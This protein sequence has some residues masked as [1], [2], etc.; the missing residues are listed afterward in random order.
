MTARY[1]LRSTAN[2]RANCRWSECFGYVV[3]LVCFAATTAAGQGASTQPR[4][5]SPSVPTRSQPAPPSPAQAPAPVLPTGV[6]EP[7]DYLIGADDLLT[8]FFWRE[9]EMSGDVAVRP[10]GRI[11]LPLINDIQA[12]GLTPAQLRL[13][14]TEAAGKYID[15]PT[16][17]VVVKT[18]NSRKVF[19]TGQIAKPGA[20]PLMAPTL[21]MQMITLAGGVLEYADQENIGILRSVN[22]KQTRLR[23][24]YKD[25]ARGKRLEQNIELKPGDTIV[26]P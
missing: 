23:F 26:V 1:R 16:V 7:A 20:Y 15:D 6:A 4:D 9:K 11:S 14:I 2:V 12:A 21:V 18:I 13:N 24:N 19:I 25:V 10:D 5:Q 17:T 3:V 8:V 22:G